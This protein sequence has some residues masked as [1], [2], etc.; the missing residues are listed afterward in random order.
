MLYEG[1]MCGLFII[2]LNGLTELYRDSYLEGRVC[3][4]L[5]QRN[6]YQ[7]DRGYISAEKT[8]R[9]DIGNQRIAVLKRESNWR[10]SAVL[11]DHLMLC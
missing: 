3:S 8:K 4:E 5:L 1:K 6:M 10:T 2:P 11:V 7:A 9:F